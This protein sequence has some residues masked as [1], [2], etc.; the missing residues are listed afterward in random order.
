MI[1]K[2]YIVSLKTSDYVYTQMYL[3]SKDN[4]LFLICYW[5]LSYG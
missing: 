5:W 4:M 3:R 1:G 2:K